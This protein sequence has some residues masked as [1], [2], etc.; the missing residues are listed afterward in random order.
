[1]TQ[2]ETKEHRSWTMSRVRSKDTAPEMAV[3]RLVHGLGYRYRLHGAELPGKP[4]LVFGARRK[5]IFVHGC[6]WHGHDCKRGSRLP[7]TRQDYWLPKL[8][9]NKERDV[10]N[11]FSL[12]QGGW[13][14]LVVWECEVK[15]KV[16]LG[17]RLTAFLVERTARS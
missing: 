13:S 8:A 1:M 2:T 6:Y 11:V 14:V 7:S 3:R 15:D 9:R 10:R 17:D 5:V 16:E 4:D 12:E